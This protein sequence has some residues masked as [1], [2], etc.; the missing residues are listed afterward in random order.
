MLLA[1][2]IDGFAAMS[3]DLAY[4]L[5][6]EKLLHIVP[7]PRAQVLRAV[8]AELGRVASHLFWLSRCA[9][10]LTDPPFAGP[11][12]AWQGRT[13]I[14]DV[15]QELGGN[16][17]T[18][19][20]VA[21]GGLKRDLDSSTADSLRSLL[22]TLQGVLDDVDRLLTHN[23]GFRAQLEGV[24]V[25]DPGT[26]LGLGVTGPCLRACGIGYDVRCAFPYAGYAS[27]EVQPAIERGND[28]DA[29]FRARIAEMHS[30][31]RLID[32]ALLQLQSGPVNASPDELPHA[33][34]PGITYASV[35]GPRGELGVLLVSDGSRHPMRVHVRAPS[36]ANLSALPFLA[37]G[38]RPNNA[39]IALDS[40]DISMGEVAR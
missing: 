8:Y 7:P 4:A 27:L 37:R 21:I 14:L 15:F 17:V 36:F 40:M 3:C 19:D 10:N 25:I 30:S 39:A 5:A 32:Q 16:P 18:P 9:Q 20:I 34:P 31:L 33:L 28:T 29:R 2:R 1:A 38:E 6:V 22:V 11:A 26:A 23:A 13:A 24:G 12:Y 35:E